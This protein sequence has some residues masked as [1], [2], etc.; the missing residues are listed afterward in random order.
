MSLEEQV[1]PQADSLCLSSV[2]P[3]VDQ[4]GTHGWVMVINM[5]HLDYVLVFSYVVFPAYEICV[6]SEE[7]CWPTDQTGEMKYVSKD[8]N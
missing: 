7:I 3:I 2:V 8:F 5:T 6:F 4:S 1:T